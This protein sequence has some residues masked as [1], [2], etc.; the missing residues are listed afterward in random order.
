MLGL[1]IV[2]A[3][4]AVLI[5]PSGRTGEQGKVGTALLTSA[6]AAAISEVNLTDRKD[7]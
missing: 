1:L 5:K 6:Q 3:A 7:W 4:A 2:G